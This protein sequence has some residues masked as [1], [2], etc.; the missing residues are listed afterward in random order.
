MADFFHFLSQPWMMTLLITVGL[1]GL[2][3]E[4]ITPGFGVPGAT[5]ILAF[6]LYFLAAYHA[7]TGGIGAPLLFVTG[8]VLLLLEM[9]VPSFGVV[10]ILGGLALAWAIISAA[11][12][13][14]TGI[15]SLLIGIVLAAAVIWF[16]IRFFGFKAVWSRLV[17]REIQRNEEGFVSTSDRRGLLDK[18]GQTITPLRPAG[19]AQFDGERVDVVSEGVVIPQGVR[20]K[21]IHVEGAR[22]VVRKVE[23]E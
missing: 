23:E 20:V 22:V 14:W 19:F 7:E 12:D 2:A 8:L 16:L 13:M 4:W 1:T 6:T 18:E 3:V 17:L 10:G 9:F 15:L 5:G 21:V 11:S